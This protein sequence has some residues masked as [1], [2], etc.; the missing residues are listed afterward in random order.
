LQRKGNRNEKG[1]T[2]GTKQL[3]LQQGRFNSFAQNRFAF[4]R[5]GLNSCFIFIIH[6]RE[7]FSRRGG[8]SDYF[9]GCKF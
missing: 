1:K 3:K 6:F 2:I 8:M 4:F 5:E 9:F 7:L